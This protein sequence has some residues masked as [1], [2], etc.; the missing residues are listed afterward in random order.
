MALLSYALLSLD[1]L[2]DYLTISGS[3][4]DNRLEEIINDTT[5]EIERFLRRQIVTRGTIVEYHTM[6]VNSRD[7]VLDELRPYQWP[8]ISIT[9]LNEDL[10]WPRTYPTSSRLVLDTDYQI[11]KGQPRDYLRRL[12]GGSIAMGWYWPTGMR[13]DNLSYAP[14]ARPIRLTYSAGFAD[15]ASVPRRIKL[16]AKRYAALLWREIDRKMQGISSQSDAL[17]NFQ[18]F[19]RG[20]IPQEMADALQDERRLEFYETA[21]AA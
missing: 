8:I 21:E 4:Q 11:V 12:A 6:K 19:W 3:G 10:N 5:D 7:L 1:E 14:A 9:E 13:D 17:G 18:R 20:E 15:T 2:K 16:Q